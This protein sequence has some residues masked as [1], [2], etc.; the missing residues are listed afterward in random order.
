MLWVE[1]RLIISREKC[2]FLKMSTDIKCELSL[3]REKLKSQRI[4]LPMNLFLLRSR[5]S[6]AAA[7]S[8]RMQQWMEVMRKSE[9]F[10]Q[11]SNSIP[12]KKCVICKRKWLE[13]CLSFSVYCETLFMRP[14]IDV[15]GENFLWICS[16]VEILSCNLAA[17]S[18]KIIKKGKR[19]IH[20]CKL[21][22]NISLL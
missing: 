3:V 2:C 1:S 12:L 17:K 4:D 15:M 16:R 20:S 13:E 9:H 19:D 10:S 7:T 11:L 22:H 8:E 5:S 18:V 21:R 14:K 6:A